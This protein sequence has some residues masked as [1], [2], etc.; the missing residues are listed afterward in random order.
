[1]QGAGADRVLLRCPKFAR[2]ADGCFKFRPL[3]L[4]FARFSRHRR[5]SQTSRPPLRGAVCRIADGTTGSLAQPPKTKEPYGCG[6]PLAGAC[7]TVCQLQAVGIGRAGSG[8]RRK[9]KGGILLL[10]V[11]AVKIQY[12]S[13]CYPFIGIISPLICK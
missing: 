12:H 9:K 1:M 11:G 7:P 6:I 4:L 5:R 10:Y 13:R 8:L 3:P 2:R